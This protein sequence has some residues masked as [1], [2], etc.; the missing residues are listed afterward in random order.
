MSVTEVAYVARAQMDADARRGFRLL[1]PRLDSDRLG[2]L[3]A[4]HHVAK[5]S[6]NLEAAL[7]ILNDARKLVNGVVHRAPEGERHRA[8]ARG[9]GH[10]T[11]LEELIIAQAVC[12]RLDCAISLSDDFR[13]NRRE[14][15]DQ[16]LPALLIR[17]VAHTRERLVERQQCLLFL[18]HGFVETCEKATS[19]ANERRHEV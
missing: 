15:V 16:A 2:E 10:Q 7:L 14:R 19:I 13:C 11:E 4:T 6:A 17:V 8:A 5:A 3:A 1:P 9:G 18:D 12:R